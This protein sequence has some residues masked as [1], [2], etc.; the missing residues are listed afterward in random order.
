[1]EKLSDLRFIIG[2]FFALAGALLL[3]LAYTA[4]GNKEFGHSLNLYAGLAMFVFGAF[5]LWMNERANRE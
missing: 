1:M 2:L 3:V 5:M 4:S